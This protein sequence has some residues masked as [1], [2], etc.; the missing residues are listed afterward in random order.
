VN[1]QIERHFEAESAPE[2]R[3]YVGDDRGG[4][5]T[6]PPNGDLIQANVIKNGPAAWS[7]PRADV[8]VPPLASVAEL[9]DI[10]SSKKR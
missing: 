9:L 7:T 3:G 6:G 10:A 4:A 8:E 1:E 5:G 2:S